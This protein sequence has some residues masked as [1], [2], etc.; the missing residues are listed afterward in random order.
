M[1]P[2]LFVDARERRA[3]GPAR[4]GAP[5]TNQLEEFRP[6]SR[7][8]AKAAEHRTGDRERVLFLDSPHRHAEMRALDDDRDA[9]RIDLLFDGL[10]DLV[11]HPFLDLQA[12]G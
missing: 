12:S 9:E 4:G 11:G 2:A 7:I 5:V 8:I 3:A 6:R 10:R 1:P